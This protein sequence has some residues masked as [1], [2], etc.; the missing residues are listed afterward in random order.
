MKEEIKE[1]FK[2]MFEIST[3]RAIAYVLSFMTLVNIAL[4]IPSPSWS[5]AMV[6][7]YVILSIVP[8]MRWVAGGKKISEME[9]KNPTKSG[10]ILTAIIWYLLM[11]LGIYASRFWVID[12][13]LFAGIV[14]GVFVFG[15]AFLKI[16]RQKE[17]SVAG[18]T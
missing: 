13:I 5:I 12:A 18:E 17:G 10:V 7:V 2:D 8:A 6:M 1:F 3:M 4:L 11:A 14:L 15:A 9:I 16:S